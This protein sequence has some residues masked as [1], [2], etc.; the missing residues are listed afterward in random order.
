MPRIQDA[1]AIRRILQRD[2]VWSVYALGDLDNERFPHSEWYTGP[3]QEALILFYR[4][5]GDPI[6]FAAGQP[7]PIAELLHEAPVAPRAYVQVS[8]EILPVVEQHYRI[9]SKKHMV[10]MSTT[11][12]AQPDPVA[13]R[14]TGE[15]LE[16]LQELYADGLEPNESPDFF[17]P[18]M[19]DT[20][21]FYG[22]FVD[23]SLVA[24]AGTHLVSVSESI[25][26]IGNVYTHRDQRGRGYAQ[27]T[28]SSVTAELQSCGIQTIAL[29]VAST[30]AAALRAYGKLGFTPHSNFY[31]AIA[32][33]P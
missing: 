29:N 9:A 26:A 16:A 18:S 15:H 22:A 20:G 5:Y 21:V 3:K 14:L 17:F 4:E 25:A 8:E 23:G 30:N 12:P 33:A 1:D 2:R 31:E 19:L 32:C 24:A 7:A 13:V 10:R 27:A 11:M 6:L 28:T